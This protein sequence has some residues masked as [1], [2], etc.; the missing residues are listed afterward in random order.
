MAGEVRQPLQ[1]LSTVSALAR[2]VRSAYG[3]RPR[4]KLL[5][6]A[7]NRVLITSSGAS[8]L[9]SLVS[10][11]PVTRWLLDTVAA[12]VA[13]AGDGATSF[14]LLLHYVLDEADALLRGRAASRIRLVRAVDWL[15]KDALPYRLFP[16]WEQ[17]TVRTDPDDPEAIRDA[18]LRLCATSLAGCF[19]AS[20]SHSLTAA[21]VGALTLAPTDGSPL[22]IDL[23]RRRAGGGISILAVGGGLARSSH[24][25]AGAVVEAQPISERMPRQLRSTRALFLGS[26]AIPP[27]DRRAGDDATSGV[28]VTIQVA[29]A[30]HR[31]GD[32]ELPRQPASEV[33]GVAADERRRWV[34][35]LR[36]A[37]VRLLLSGTSVGAGTVPLCVE[38]GV[39]VLQGVDSSDLHLLARGL[40]VSPLRAFPRATELSELATS[41]GFVADAVSLDCVRMGSKWWCRVSSPHAEELV[42]CTVRA[43]TA[44]LALEYRKAS[45]RALRSLRLWMGPP[46]RTEGKQRAPRA[47][48]CEAQTT[49]GKQRAPRASPCEAQTTE[50]KQRAPRASPCEA[51]TTEGKQRAP[52]ASP[53]EAQTTEGKQ[54]APRASPCEAQT[55]EGKQ[56]ATR[57]ST[58]EAQT[59]WVMRSVPGA[60]AAEMQLCALL[61]KLRQ[62]L[63][64][65]FEACESQTS[66]KEGA[67]IVGGGKEDTAS[68]SNC[69]GGR[70]AELAVR[71]DALQLVSSALRR[72]ARTFHENAQ[73]RQGDRHTAE[74]WILNLHALEKAHKNSPTCSLGLVD[75]SRSS[76]KLSL[77]GESDATNRCGV[78]V[79][80][81]LAAGILEPMGCKVLLIEDVLRPFRRHVADDSDPP[82]DDDGSDSAGSIEST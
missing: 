32:S 37:G 67:G 9:A 69:H 64:D 63:T 6:S 49:E 51:Q 21:L 18:A 27:E 62:D 23:V 80:D 1:L 22:P 70:G 72:L 4:E 28:P 58:C 55:T 11:H 25:C 14:V 36:D 68:R 76:V 34:R 35:A 8:I 42:T 56:C 45:E 61:G 66:S 59:Q 74:R 3:P 31:A 19:G 40:G 43:P 78:A 52:R 54:R 82:S 5:I 46:Q 38:A 33:M 41:P 44:G 79:A 16:S 2:V 24:G 48:P 73:M 65:S 81:A 77:H 13:H 29:A 20:V 57:A 30:A 47:S 60:C 39:C 7:T 10:D 53:C 50:G 15:R 12:H 17:Q 75:S 71:V 26:S